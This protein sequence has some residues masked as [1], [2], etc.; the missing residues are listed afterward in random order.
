MRIVAAVSLNAVATIPRTKGLE[1]RMAAN[2]GVDWR[3]ALPWL[4]RVIESDSAGALREPALIDFR[5]RLEE[6]WNTGP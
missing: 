3:L 2:S 5:R 1:G 4:G 6:L